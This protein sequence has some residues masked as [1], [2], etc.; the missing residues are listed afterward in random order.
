MRAAVLHGRGDLRVAEVPVPRPG[1]GE[2]LLRVGAVGL[3]GTDAA[4]Y[5]YGPMMF[6]LATPHPVTGHRGPMVIGHEFAGEVVAVGEGVDRAW[7]GRLLASCGSI[8]CGRCRH[9]RAGRTNLCERYA[10]VGLHRDGAAAEYVSAPLS[11][12]EPADERGLPPD[13]AALAQPMSIAVHAA[14][15][16]RVAAGERVVLLGAGGIGAFLTHVLASRG[17]SLLVVDPDDGRRDLAAR[18]GAAAVAPAVDEVAPADALGG[19]PDVVVEASGTPGGLDAAL[20]ALPAGARLLVVGLQKRPVALDLRR[21][22]VAENEI[23]GTNAMARTP[24]FAEAMDLVA[25]RNDGWADVA[26]VAL[27]LAEVA[28]GALAPMAAGRSPAVKVLV[29][30]ATTGR[31]PTRTVPE[32]REIRS[33]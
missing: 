33:L 24:D 27:P 20:S 30:P 29:D 17:A 15:R 3:C 2:V 6:P 13:A 26:P 19:R 7:S 22:T 21:A 31:R 28:T 16:G 4:E 9:C 18:L 10:A 12:C 1:P 5:A 11:S 32:R 23:I 25:A 14:R 8:L